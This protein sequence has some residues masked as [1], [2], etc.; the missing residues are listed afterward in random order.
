[1]STDNSQQTTVITTSIQLTAISIQQIAATIIT[2]IIR[3]TV[4]SQQS[5]VITTTMLTAHSPKLIAITTSIQQI[6]ATTITTIIR[7]TVNSQQS[8]VITTTM[9]TAHSPKLT[10]HSPKLIAIITA[11][12]PSTSQS[13]NKRKSILKWLK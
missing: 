13:T 7:S 8:T 10:A 6:A 5:T 12:A 3:S 2:T 9:L 11:K 4:N 1:M